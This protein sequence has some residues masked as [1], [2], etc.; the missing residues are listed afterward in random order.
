MSYRD[1]Y[2]ILGVPRTASA[3]ELKRA[4]RKLAM[5]WHPDRNPGDEAAE[6][7]FKD[8]SEAYRTLGDPVRRARYDRLGP[9]YTEDGR[10]PRPDEVNEAVG[11]VWSNLFSWRNRPKR[12][13]DLR[14]TISLTLEEVAAGVDK[15]LSVPRRI[16]CRTCDGVGADADGRDTC[17]PCEGTGR[18]RGPRLLRSA[19]YRCG[20]S[21]WTVRVPCASCAGHGQVDELTA[22]RVAVPAGVA[23]GQKLKVRGRGNEPSRAGPAGDLYVVVNV[24]DHALF[25]RRG[26]DVLCDVPMRYA[27]LVLGAEVEIPTLRG[28]TT[29]RVPSGTPPGK[30]FRLSGRG[31]PSAS[32]ARRGD[33][34]VQVVLEIPSEL[35][36][37]E[38]N[39]LA[40]W[41]Q[42]LPRDRHP[43][44]E[45]FAAAVQERR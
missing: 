40:D 33:L 20:G 29:I 11:A 5:Q 31:L 13:D 19:C 7:H 36:D 26:E 32:R 14:F 18:S 28:A 1:F 43:R 30:V 37:A 34:H 17:S 15:S 22:I 21:G 24:A 35:S 10:P 45:T 39:H 27:D 23:T 9:L 3:D 2:N 42:G 8:V 6:R 44:R 4:Y 41:A 25:R 38:R 16:R 12:G